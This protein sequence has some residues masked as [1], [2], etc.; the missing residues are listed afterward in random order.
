MFKSEFQIKK[1]SIVKRLFSIKKIIYKCVLSEN[2][3][4]STGKIN[5]PVFFLGKGKI[6][7]DKTAELGYSPS[8][9]FYSGY[10]HVEART[11]DSEISVGEKTVI[12]NGAVII[13]ARAKI[14]IGQ[15]CL[16][17]VNFHC[18]SSDFHGLDPE[19]RD[20]YASADIS[21]GDHVFIGNNV[22][23]LKGSKIGGGATIAAG[24]VVTKSFPENAIIGGNPAK[25]IRIFEK[26]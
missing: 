7:I 24:A 11:R 8:P 21:I 20:E 10:M 22:T 4:V 18:I 15:N 12:N 9:Y 13:A 19:N 3:P 5:Q 14:K 26:R 23:I 25:L 17:G 16:I 2:K 1:K 6:D